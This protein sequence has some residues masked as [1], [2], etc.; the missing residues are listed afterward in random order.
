MQLG[1]QRFRLSGKRSPVEVR[2]VE[3]QVN[4]ALER[5]R[6]QGC[7]PLESALLTAL[8]LCIRVLEHE[9]EQHRTAE[10]QAA[11]QQRV[12]ALLALLEQRD[13]FGDVYRPRTAEE[14]ASPGRAVPSE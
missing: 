11:D 1:G 10:R 5:W 9:Q 7:T 3:E 12:E 14:M 13:V 6:G 4:Q 2:R 8:N